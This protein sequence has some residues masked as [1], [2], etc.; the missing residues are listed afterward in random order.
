[1]KKNLI[2]VIIPIYNVEE[3]L[4]KCIDSIVMQTY[5]NL[6]IILVNDGSPDNCSDICEKWEKKDSRVIYLQKK[7]GGLSSARNYGIEHCSGDYIVFVDS[8]DYIENNMIEELYNNL[9]ENDSDVA[10]CGFYNVKNEKKS[11]V[12]Y[13]KTKF[14]ASNMEK[15]ENLYN[16]YYLPTTIAWN[17]I[18]KRHIFDKIRYA[19]GKYHE[20]EFI[21]FD[22]LKIAD[23][24]SYNLIP[25]YNYL[26]RTG[27]IT[28]RFTL[29][30][31][32]CLEAIEKRNDYYVKN[33][34]D[35][36][37]YLNMQSELNIIATFLTEY[38]SS[39]N[40]SC[41]KNIIIDFEFIRFL[42]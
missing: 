10:I 8:D 37:I 13:S 40:N 36:L 15:F 1:M 30:R 39:K 6:E 27:S 23:K 12:K 41:D 31:L 2:S 17:K 35:D 7:N 26:Y 19:E 34:R 5:E 38:Y 11:A 16:E 20:D 25:L 29:K 4:E 9:K 32:D 42:L 21:I 14:V 22:I 3:Y 28:K 18:Y 24:I 33:K